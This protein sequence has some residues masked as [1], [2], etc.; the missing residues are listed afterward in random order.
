MIMVVLKKIIKFL[1]KVFSILYLRYKFFLWYFS[2]IMNLFD[3]FFFGINFGCFWGSMGDIYGGNY[4]GFYS[5]DSDVE[6]LSFL[7]DVFVGCFVVY[8]GKE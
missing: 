3:V 1:R 8:V 7:F 4:G 5:Y 6:C 2:V